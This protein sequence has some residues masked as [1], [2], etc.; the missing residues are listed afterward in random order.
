MV[1]NLLAAINDALCFLLCTERRKGTKQKQKREKKL[2]D[3]KKTKE[4][5][6]KRVME[7]EKEV[8]LKWFFNKG[9]KNL[10]V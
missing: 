1:A 7:N 9:E 8:K 4:L 5:K 6:I 2:L 10:K 3:K